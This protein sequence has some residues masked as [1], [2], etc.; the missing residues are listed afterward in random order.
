MK[1]SGNLDLPVA[2]LDAPTND[3][4]TFE[5][6]CRLV[7]GRGTLNFCGVSVRWSVYDGPV[8]AKNFPFTFGSRIWS[9][10]GVGIQNMG[11]Q[12][13]VRGSAYEGFGED[14]FVWHRLRVVRRPGVDGSDW[15]QVR[16]GRMPSHFKAKGSRIALGLKQGGSNGK[17]LL[18]ASRTT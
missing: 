9:G 14:P 7:L 11:L 3:T 18:Q 10:N 17:I 12:N 13:Y 6:D 4:Y 5:V 15:V 1:G 16:S 2:W 8:G